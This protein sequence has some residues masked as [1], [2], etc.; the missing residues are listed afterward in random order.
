MVVD[1]D[2]WCMQCWFL[3]T[4]FSEGKVVARGTVCDCV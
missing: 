3:V 1:F 2:N 4:H